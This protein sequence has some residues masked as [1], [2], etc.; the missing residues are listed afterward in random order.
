MEQ[1]VLEP[2]CLCDANIIEDLPA[3]PQHP[4]GTSTNEL[5]SWGKR[6]IYEM[7]LTLGRSPN[8]NRIRSK[9]GSCEMQELFLKGRKLLVLRLPEPSLSS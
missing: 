5:K 4:A 3:I 8:V 6:N 7:L 9:F 2:M 1:L